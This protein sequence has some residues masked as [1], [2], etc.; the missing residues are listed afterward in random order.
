MCSFMVVKCEIASHAR[1]VT[2]L[3]LHP[4]MPWLV[5]VSEDTFVNIWCPLRQSNP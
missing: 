1:G 2:A 4:S 3:A 5:S